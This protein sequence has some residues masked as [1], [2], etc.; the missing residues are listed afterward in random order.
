VKQASGFGNQDDKDPETKWSMLQMLRQRQHGVGPKYGSFTQFDKCKI[1]NLF[2]PNHKERTVVRLD[3]KIFCGVF[4]KDGKKFVTGSQDQNIRIFD[5]STPNYKLEQTIP[6][7]HVSWCILD[8]DFSKDGQ[9]LVYSS[10]FD[11]SEY[12][13]VGFLG[14]RPSLLQLTGRSPKT[15]FFYEFLI[16][17]SSFVE[18]PLR[19]AKS[20]CKL[21]CNK[22]S[23][24][25]NNFSIKI[26]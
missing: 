7:K 19:I 20:T 12:F 22:S 13:N 15:L 16:K 10:W 17:N 3:S 8:L 21:K 18:D 14:D 9:Y 1:N 2:L 24:V 11:C 6:A 4:S 23:K 26:I 5:S 25:Q